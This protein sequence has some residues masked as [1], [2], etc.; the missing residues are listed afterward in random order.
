MS[1]GTYTRVHASMTQFYNDWAHIAVTHDQA[2][3]TK[4]AIYVNGEQ[5]A[6]GTHD[7]VGVGQVNPE[8][9]FDIPEKKV[10]QSLMLCSWSFWSEVYHK[11]LIDEFRIWNV[12][13]TQAQVRDDMF[14]PLIKEDGSLFLDRD[15]ESFC[16]LVEYLRN[17]KKTE[18]EFRSLRER[19][20]F[21]KE[22][23]F[24][25]IEPRHFVDKPAERGYY[26]K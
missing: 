24:W 2:S 18:P 26:N 16:H 21:F 22:L 14:K 19:K 23:E 20:L 6:E 12:S 11:G 3:G 25:K 1:V 5:L 8:I 9:D 13:K 17:A 7:Y 4:M 15:G 10:V